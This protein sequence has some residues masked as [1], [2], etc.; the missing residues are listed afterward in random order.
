MQ[1]APGPWGT[2]VLEVGSV[3]DA[4]LVA[5]VGWS[6]QPAAVLA[7]PPQIGEAVHAHAGLWWV[8]VLGWLTVAEVG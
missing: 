5:C 8:G 4:L 3:K 6:L 2:P 1:A 7:E